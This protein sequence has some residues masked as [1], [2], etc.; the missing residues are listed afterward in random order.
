MKK[1]L[2]IIMSYLLSGL[3]CFNLSAEDDLADK[4]H[5]HRTNPTTLYLLW[6]FWSWHFFVKP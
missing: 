3:L 5:I 4:I 2:V 1:V 6:T